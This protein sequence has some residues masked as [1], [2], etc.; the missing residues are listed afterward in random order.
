MSDVVKAFLEA[1]GRQLTAVLSNDTT[2]GEELLLAFGSEGLVFRCNEDSDAL[3][4]SLEP[5]PALDDAEDLTA[6]PI[7]SRF[8]GKEFSTG[9]L[10]MNQHGYCDGAL[11]S[12]DGVVPEVGLN[13]VAAAF[14][15]LEVRQRA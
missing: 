15:I 5:L 12:F 2:E 4:I 8:L 9:W 11:L 10:M 1:Q 14:E 6:H 7:W 3:A 13:V